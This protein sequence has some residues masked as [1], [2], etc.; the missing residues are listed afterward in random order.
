MSILLGLQK[1][2]RNCV[3]SFACGIAEHA[4]PNQKE[5]WPLRGSPQPGTKNV[6]HMPPVESNK[7][8]LP[9]LH[10]KLGLMKNFVKAIDRDGPA[11]R[12]LHEKFHTLGKAKI[13]EGI[14]IGPQIRELLKDIQFDSIITG[15]ETAA[16]E[17]FR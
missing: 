10:I 13:K 7:I 11:F 2:I 8:V 15:N 4:N 12:Y 17:A 9:P 1:V 14:F 16:W 5:D 3:A 6:M